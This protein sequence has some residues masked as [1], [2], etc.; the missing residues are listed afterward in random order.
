MNQSYVLRKACLRPGRMTQYY[1]LKKSIAIIWDTMLE[2]D[3]TLSYNYLAFMEPTN[4]LQE[5]KIK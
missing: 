1:V 5:K 4:I 3:R 2:A